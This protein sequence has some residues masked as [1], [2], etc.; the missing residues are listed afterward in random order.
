M[1][2][3]PNIKAIFIAPSAGEPMQNL[4]KGEIISTGLQGDRYANSTGAYSNS[5]PKKIRHLT[6][7]TEEAI[8]IANEQLTSCNAP[9]YTAAQTRRN[10]V[11][12][13]M[14]A[15]T[16]NQLVGKTFML[17]PLILKGI[18][19]CAPCERPGQ[20]LHK[21]GFMD[22]FKDRG[23]LRAEVLNVGTILIGDEL[24]FN[25]KDLNDSLPQ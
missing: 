17:G 3:T 12:D 10:I 13:H 25:R 18:E 9:T 14:G 4:P 1:S 8:R 22:A 23:G 21:A 5:T 16:L 20:L 6:L 24:R 19:L 7:I 11:I 15:D 2:Q